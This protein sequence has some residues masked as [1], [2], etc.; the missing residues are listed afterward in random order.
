MKGFLIFN[1]I[2]KGLFV[3][4]FVYLVLIIMFS[5]GFVCLF[6]G[7]F[8]YQCGLCV[9]RPYVW[10][11]VCLFVCLSS[12]CLTWGLLVCVFGDLMFGIGLVCLCVCRPYVWHGVCQFVWLFD[13][14]L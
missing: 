14:C 5:N 4:G 8:C 2:L 7:R 3:I 6:W 1:P 9:C 12:L 10:H 11:W 13:L